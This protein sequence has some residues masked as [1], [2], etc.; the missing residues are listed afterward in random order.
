M[1]MCLIQSLLLMD[2]TLKTGRFNMKAYRFKITLRN[3][4]PPIWRRI[5][6]PAAA[7]FDQFSKII[8]DLFAFEGYHMA[9]F[10]FPNLDQTM[11]EEMDNYGW[12][13]H[14]I[15]A[16][17]CLEEF[18][19][20]KRFIY[21]YDF[22]DNWE[23]MIQQEEIMDYYAYNYPTLLKYKGDN[24]IEDVGGIYGYDQIR[25]AWDDPEF[26]ANE[27]LMEMAGDQD[28]YRF[29]KEAVQEKLKFY[30]FSETFIP[31]ESADPED[32]I[33]DTPELDSIQ[34]ILEQER[35]P[36]SFGELA[37]FAAL[38]QTQAVAEA[39][40]RISEA[41]R[42]PAD[43]LIDTITG[44]EEEKEMIEFFCSETSNSRMN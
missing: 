6:V 16:R 7:G 31:D 1:M 14:L 35:L 29:E 25:S 19:E 11:W 44:S 4:H 10:R 30:T 36:E 40:S 33:D 21:T 20:D 37:A 41:Y 42:I 34:E 5:I 28:L 26:I 12:D 3:S 13:S 2:D 8:Q 38:V 27:Y 9:E 39:V 43:D 22:G 15:M 24:L 17:H 23:F 32:D 18:E